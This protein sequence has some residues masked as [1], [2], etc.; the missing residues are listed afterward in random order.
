MHACMGRNAYSL[1]THAETNEERICQK[2]SFSTEETN[3][4]QRHERICEEYGRFFFAALIES[5]STHHDVSI[6]E[7]KTIRIHLFE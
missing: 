3:T 2:V 6:V 5:T 7:R 1:L 4:E